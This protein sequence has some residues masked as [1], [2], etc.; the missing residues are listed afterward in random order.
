[1]W[2]RRGGPKRTSHKL[3][4]LAVIDETPDKTA[5]IG[6]ASIIS[7]GNICF[8]CGLENDVYDTCALDV[9]GMIDLVVVMCLIRS[10]VQI[11]APASVSSG[12]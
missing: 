5:D 3:S 10:V 6:A 2:R 12:G 9:G 11:F 8:G 7:K 4:V 1:L